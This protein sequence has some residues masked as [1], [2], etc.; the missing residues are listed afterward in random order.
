MNRNYLICNFYDR[1][2]IP[3]QNVIATDFHI[4]I[5][6]RSFVWAFVIERL[7]IMFFIKI[8]NYIE[9]GEIRIHLYISFFNLKLIGRVFI[10]F[11]KSNT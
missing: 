8:M 5:S 11:V 10:Y 3:Q 9:C 6:L 2:I 7:M 4:G 1:L